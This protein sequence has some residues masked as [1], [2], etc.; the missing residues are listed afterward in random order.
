MSALRPPDLGY[1]RHDLPGYA[2]VAGGLVPGHVLAG[3][4][5]ERRQR[6][7]LADSLGVGKLQDGMD[8]AAQVSSCDGAV[9]PRPPEW[10]NGSR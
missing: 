4:P 6:T 10:A 8:V 7:W 5:K 2:Q 1:G 3:E 9:W